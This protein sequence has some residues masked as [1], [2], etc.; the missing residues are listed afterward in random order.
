MECMQFDQKGGSVYCRVADLS[1][2]AYVAIRINASTL[3]QRL[4]SDQ[5]N[6]LMLFEGP[7]HCMLSQ[8]QNAMLVLGSWCELMR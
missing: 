4:C 6:V 7:A 3:C 1:L 2:A 5:V 8:L